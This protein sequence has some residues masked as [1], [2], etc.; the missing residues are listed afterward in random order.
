[1]QKKNQDDV[2]LELQKRRQQICERSED[3]DDMK[4]FLIKIGFPRSLAGKNAEILVLD[5]H[6]ASEKLFQ[7]KKSEEISKF[8][9]YLDNDGVTLLNE[10]FKSLNLNLST[11]PPSMLSSTASPS[12]SSKVS[13]QSLASN[14]EVVKRHWNCFMVYYYYYYSV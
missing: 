4:N 7:L 3:I 13:V 5:F 12:A 2:A 1:M 10:Y 9:A 6:V 8:S 14:G 11:S